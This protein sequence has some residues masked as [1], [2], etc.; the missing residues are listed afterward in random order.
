M[1]TIADVMTAEVIAVGPDATISEI[2]A[3]LYTRRIS[4][5][6]VVDGDGSGWAWSAKAI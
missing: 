5:V 6:V 4:G 2:A 1:V 3:L